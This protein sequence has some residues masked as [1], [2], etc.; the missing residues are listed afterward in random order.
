MRILVVEDE[1]SL[2]AALQRGLRAEGFAVDL[3]EDGLD[4][5]ARART[6]DYD[7]VVLDVMLPGQSGYRVVQALSA[8][9]SWVPVLML[10]AKDGEHDEADALDVGAERHRQLFERLSEN[11]RD[12]LARHRA[13]LLTPTRRA[14]SSPSR[15]GARP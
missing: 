12:P 15:R 10:T 6:G 3:S 2:A 7:A 1:R 13:S 5:L 4:G 9:G 8:E 14:R 11:V